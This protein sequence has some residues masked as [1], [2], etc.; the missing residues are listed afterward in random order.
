MKPELVS[1]PAARTHA[2]LD[3]VSRRL[4]AEKIERL[5]GLATASGSLRIL[6]VGCGSG[7]IA[8]YFGTLPMQHEVDAVDVV[9]SRVVHEGFRFQLVAGTIL[10][11]PDDTFDVVISNHVI[12]HVGDDAAQ[13][14]HLRELTRVISSSGVG[15]LAVPNRWRLIEP[16]YR[17]PL[18]SVWPRRWRSTYLR[19][20]RR[21]DEYDCEPL[22]ARELEA[23]F[24][25]AGLRYRRLGVQAVRATIDLEH[26]GQ[27]VA[28]VL[29]RV[30]DRALRLIEPMMPTLIYRIERS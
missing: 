2:L 23:M 10:P 5:L 30:P 16:H 11:F 28:S 6:E 24:A 8:N 9:D 1:V 13:L 25:R 19:L 22:E 17:L 14:E 20:F 26:P 15:Y 3:L 29:R 12:E 21:G 4:K 27:I 7:G 18:L